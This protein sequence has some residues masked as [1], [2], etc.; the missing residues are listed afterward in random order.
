MF[1]RTCL[2][3]LLVAGVALAV[4]GCTSGNTSVSSITV[5][6][7]AQS[8]AVGQ[9]A[10]FTASGTVLHGTHPPTTQDETSSVTWSS[11][12][13]AIATV[14]AEGLA[15][16][17]AA[18]TA[19]ITATVPGGSVTPAVGTI[20]VTGSGGGQTVSGDV[21]AITVIPGT[22]AVASAGNT[23]Q[24]FAIGTTSTGVTE[25][26]SGLVAWS[27]SSTNIVTINSSTGF[28]TGAA[29]GTATITALFTNP[30]KTV[31]AGTATFTV[32]GPIAEEVT[33]LT[34]T[35]TQQSLSASGQTGQFLALGTSGTT[36]LKLNVTDATGISWISTAPTVASV[37]ATTGLVTGASPGQ[38]T[39]TA[40][41]TNPDG[42]ASSASAVVNVTSS[43]APEPL[44]SLIII[45]SAITVGNLQDTGNFLAIG[46]F[47]TPPTV[48]D[49]TNS[50]TW[51]SSFP[52]IF[53]V[54]TNS[55]SAN[56]AVPGGV[57]TAYGDGSA[58]IIA[59]AIDPT[60]G[61]IQTATATFACPLVLPNPPN[62]AGS[63]YEGSQAA[64]LLATLTVYNE[65]GNTTNW[66][67]TASSATGTADVIHCGPGWTGSGGQV[68]VATYPVGTTV[69]LT[70][71]QPAGSTGTFGGWSDNCTS[72]SP[73]P[74]TAAGPN[75]CTIAPDPP[76]YSDSN[77][78]PTN[79]TVGAIF[80]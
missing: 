23:T 55:G 51:I 25:N 64:S 62:V 68:C 78:A 48:R 31:A 29:P 60:T 40:I 8:V 65:G 41:F 44:Q 11:S 5:S 3:A 43:P 26:L 10:Q 17:V 56:P 13:P 18:G 46:T 53:P 4:S 73:N 6:P 58:T 2:N 32:Q 34:V 15:T 50:V 37:G 20:T 28:A 1:R 21:T 70:A 77:P 24:F 27:S 54:D 36:G 35:P 42:T 80:N 76:P 12:A 79:I 7:T 38:T 67:V 74:S 66:L 49:L 72:I 71:T 16:A 30:D 22:Q 69:T 63:C 57:V 9:T 45:P 47:S 19:T 75:T 39:I 52:N 61:S 14:N 59:E 33:A